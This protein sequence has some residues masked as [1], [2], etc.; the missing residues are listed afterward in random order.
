VDDR[1][2]RPVLGVL[3]P[4][5]V[6]LALVCGATGL[7]LSSRDILLALIFAFL[8]LCVVH[9]WVVRQRAQGLAQARAN[10]RRSIVVACLL[11]IGASILLWI[12]LK[13]HKSPGTRDGVPILIFF[14][15]LGAVGRVVE[16]RRI[17]RK[18]NYMLEPG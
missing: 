11:F 17:L 16:A 14:G 9:D 8:G 7:F 10:V 1:D 13:Q 2:A 15:Y 4:T 5:F 6:G 18:L 3:A 12:E